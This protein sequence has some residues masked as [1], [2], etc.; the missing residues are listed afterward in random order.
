MNIFYW[1]VNGIILG[2]ISFYYWKKFSN[3]LRFFYWPALFAK[4]VSGV[5][6]GWIYAYF[7]TQSDTWNFFNAATELS[8]AARIN[9]GQYLDYLF[10]VRH[11][12]LGQERSDFLIKIIS[13]VN[14]ITNDNSIITSFYFSLFSFLGSFFLVRVISTYYPTLK[15]SAL[16]SFLFFPS[17]VFWSSGIIKETIAIPCLFY[18]MALFLLRWNE[19]RVIGYQYV[20]AI[21][22]I[23]IVW[24]LKYYYLAVFI[25]ICVALLGVKWFQRKYNIQRL[26]YQFMIF[27]GFSMAMLLMVSL[28]HPNL[29]LHRIPEVIVSNYYATVALSEAGDVVHFDNLQPTWLSILRYVPKAIFSGMFRPFVWEADHFLKISVATEHMVMLLGSVI[30][31]LRLKKW[32]KRADAILLAGVLLYCFSL[33]ALL[34][35]AMPNFGTLVRYKVAFY[36][37]V[38]LAVFSHPVIGKLMKY[39]ESARHKW[40][41]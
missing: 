12:Y 13:V 8:K 15:Y 34:T 37:I 11:S 4:L 24:F 39:L 40:H 28:L 18:C 21:V 17:A 16:I 23:L 7:Y 2:V 1:I 31:I 26:K 38:V 27:V 36:P 19:D 9:P 30:F 10:T 3:E 14:L 32:F 25:P 20:L 35:L 41:S 5:A 29:F 22:A 33:C 6:L